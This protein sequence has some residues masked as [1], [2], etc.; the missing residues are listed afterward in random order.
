MIITINKTSKIGDNIEKYIIS[1]TKQ[2]APKCYQFLSDK[3][4][5]KII[6]KIKNKFN[7]NIDRHV[8][9]SINSSYMKDYII[10]NYYKVK[11]YEH[12]LLQEYPYTNILV[13]SGKYD[14]SPVTIFKIIFEEKYKMKLSL[15]I[16]NKNILEEYDLKQFNNAMENDIY[17]QLDQ[18]K[19][20][21]DA[22]IF[23]RDVEKFLIKN[24]VKYKHQN[25]LIEE[26]T[27]IYGHAV[28]TPDFLIESELIINS[29]KINWIDAKNFYGAN[30]KF[31]KNKI[32]KQIGKYINQY[33]SGCII[34]RWGYNE[35]LNIMNTLC[36]DYNNLE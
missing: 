20:M 18:S 10:N 5:N 36:I 17:F 14:L 35:N 11:K 32:K 29:N 21:N 25:Q 3:T 4:I 24:N 15:I 8:I 1:K 19:S 34:F 26:Q 31:L 9:I 2:S 16:K 28:N 6:K 30:I 13:L 7:L 27:R 23:E 33:G 12:Q 22:E